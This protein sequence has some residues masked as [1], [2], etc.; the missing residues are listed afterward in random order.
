MSTATFTLSPGA[1]REAYKAANGRLNIWEGA[2]RAGK[3][4]GSIWRWIKFVREAPLGPL[5]MIGKTERTL[6]RNI[7]DKMV[8]WLGVERCKFIAGTGMIEL[9]GRRIYIVGANDER[10]QEKIRGMTLV[11]FYA[12]EVSTLPESF[13]QMLMSRMSVEGAKGFGTTNPDAPNHWLKKK[14]LDRAH[15]WRHRDGTWHRKHSR[16]ALDVRRFSFTIDDNPH[17]PLS[18]KENI[19][20][21]YVGL[22]YR[23]FILGEWVQA[24]GAI[25][26]A[27]DHEKHV[28]RGPLD[29][30][31]TVKMVSVGVDYGTRN[32]F[33]AVELGISMV[34]KPHLVA[35]REYRWDPQIKRKQKTDA[36]FSRDMRAWMLRNEQSTDP[37][38]VAVDPSAASFRVQ[39]HQDRV[40]GLTPA[41]NDVLDGIRLVGSL[42]AQDQL[43]IHESCTGLVDELPAYSWD[44][45][46]AEK[47]E[48]AP[49]KVDD[50]SCDALRYGIYTPRVVWEPILRGRRM[51]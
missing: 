29:S 17:L 32:P 9:C 8:E 18:Y 49:V 42:F 16:H 26:E 37:K 13:F 40:K 27:F 46:K 12:D 22:W 5:L 48:D 25:Y 50:H 10:A 28:L 4:D 1:Q 30:R 20:K 34:G 19:K 33:S 24:E 39:L 47:G 23:R 43:Y 41:N 2:V 21:E 15:L 6:Q 11:G 14:Y 44:D 7:I 35:T 31:Y 3:T 51:A 45:D 36:E 38:Y